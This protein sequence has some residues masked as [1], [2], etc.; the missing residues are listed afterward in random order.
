MKS[1]QET[2]RGD[3]LKVFQ[4]E[5]VE[6]QKFS[7]IERFDLETVD[8]VFDGLD[9]RHQSLTAAHGVV[10]G[11]GGMAGLTANIVVLVTLNLWATWQVALGCGYDISLSEE[12]EYVL[13]ILNMDTLSGQED[14][15]HARQHLR[16]AVGQA[17]VG[18]RDCRA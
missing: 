11:L 17:T 14:G 12:R 15:I 13:N 10:A 1:V 5:G 6:V 18:I 16:F 7:N 2:S 8:R 4:A 9:L 3:M